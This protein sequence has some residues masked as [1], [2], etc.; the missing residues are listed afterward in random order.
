[1]KTKDTTYSLFHMKKL[2][3]FVFL[4]ILLISCGNSENSSI[5]EVIESGNLS[6]IRK[7]KSELG[8]QQSELSRQISRLDEAIE[9]LDE[10]RDR[11]L[12]NVITLKDTVFR[13]YSEV[14]GNVATDQNIIIYPE[15]AGILA[16]VRVTEGQDVVRGQTLAVV[17]DGGL[18]SE[19]TRLETQLALAKT[20]FERQERLWNQNIGSEMQY[21]E[22]RSNF[23]SA[24][25][26]VNQI[27]TQ[28]AKSTIRAPFSGVIDEVLTEQGEVVSPGQNQ[29][30]RLVSLQNMYVEANVPENYLPQVK[31]GT[32]VIVEINS[33]GKQ[34]TGEVRRV[35]NT[36][37]PNNRTFRIEVAIPNEDGM[38]R[39][40]Q[41]ATVRI[42]DY[43]HEDAIVLPEHVV[44]QNAEGEYLVYV[45]ERQ[46]ENTGVARRK[47]VETGYVQQGNMEITEGLETGETIIT[48]GSRNLRDGQEV[49]TRN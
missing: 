9:R 36:I 11:P 40:N 41:I 8:Q 29:L 21:L 22:A 48:D 26:A 13:H 2:A 15:T 47:V 43:T 20:T 5:N 25:S 6:E 1:M 7:K 14:P 12:V 28:L 33:I 38:I 49:Q 3:A 32:E 17:D 24:R 46:S 4:S 34:F 18:S 30:F 39:P 37:N 16:D 19:L 45:W 35:G 42:N 10:N 23:E 27:R 31:E 44:Q